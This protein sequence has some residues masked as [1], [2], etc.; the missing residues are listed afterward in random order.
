MEH[1]MHLPQPVYLADYAV[2]DFLIERID[3][4]FRLDE[5]KTRV[6]SVLSV[7]RNLLSK[8]MSMDLVLNG[9]QLELISVCLD[10]RALTESEY[11]LTDDAMTIYSP[12]ANNTFEVKVDNYINPKTNTSLEGMYFSNGMLCTQCEAQGFRKI[13]FYLDRPDV[14]SC[15]KTTII[16]D[17]NRFPILLSNGNKVDSGEL[18]GNLHWVTWDDPYHKPCYLFALVAGTLECLEDEFTTASGRAVALQ[19]FVEPKDLD[20]CE[21]AMQS[22]KHAM[23]WD[24]QQYGL[25]YDLDLYMIV[26]VE[27]FNMGAMENKGLNIFNSKFVLA[28]PETATDS[29]YEDI[30]SVIAHE[31]FHNWSGNRITCRDWFQLSLKEGFTVYR[32][33]EFTADRTSHAV[34]RIKDVINLRTR[35]YAED[36]GPLAHPVRPSSYI[37]INNFYTLT[38]YEKGAELIRMLHCLVGQEGFRQGCDLYFSCFDGQ[39]VTCDDFLRV[40]EETNKIDLTQFSYWYSQSGTPIVTLDYS[41]DAITKQVKLA[42]TQSH[43]ESFAQ[44]Y[45]KPLCIPIKIAL[46]STEGCELNFKVAGDDQYSNEAVLKLT[47]EKQ[48]VV[49]NEVATKPI[50]S[51]LRGF[52]SPIKLNCA[53]SN[54]EL[55]FLFKNDSDTFSRWEAGQ[56]LLE[57]TLLNLVFDIQ[58]GNALHL[59]Q[60]IIDTFKYILSQTWDDLSYLSLLLSIPSEVYLAEQM[61][62]IDVVSIHK[63]REF[64]RVTLANELHDFFKDYYLSYH[65]KN[66]ACCFNQKAISNRKIKNICL[67]YLSTLDCL[68][69]QNWVLKQFMTTTNMTDQIAALSI[70]VNGHHPYSAQSLD[71]FYN[72]WQSESLVIDKWFSVQAGSSASTTFF[73]VKS[74]MMH[75]EFDLKNP[76]R[77]RS[78]IGTFSQA[79]SLHFHAANGQG[80]RLLADTI[81]AL[82]DINPQIAAKMSM[83]LTAWR[84]YDENRQA[85]MI[86]QLQRIISIQHISK[87]VYEVVNKSLI[88]HH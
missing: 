21:F 41:Y 49:L 19:I 32:D 61:K 13:T 18:P 63:A 84:R 88:N 46:L 85:L 67:Y 43:S 3:L 5:A 27:Y 23:R 52:S 30:E 17:K 81:I 51:V 77:V 20:K 28:R 60:I 45:K 37:E 47:H 70:M 78:L 6:S 26:A 74:L 68:S 12:P 25:E 22:L 72:K 38:V 83:S 65:K 73:V 58:Q 14:M 54:E 66:E 64:V 35:Q 79:N 80:Y 56:Q 82:N 42:M 75:P 44:E 59:D 55:A 40:F 71:D 87:D 34:K 33:Q 2:P 9:E 53:R 62:I 39:A 11:S 15:Y 86:S 76:N 31:Y 4:T 24:E 8:S 48:Y 36:A 7:K 10:G 29:D 57:K 16:A 50:L 1:F 69:I